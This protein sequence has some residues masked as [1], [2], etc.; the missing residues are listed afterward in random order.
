MV[1]VVDRRGDDRWCGAAV[2]ER[3]T[4]SERYERALKRELPAMVLPLIC[5]GKTLPA[6]VLPL[7]RTDSD[8]Q[9]TVG[10]IGCNLLVKT[11]VIYLYGSL[12][13][14]IGIV[15]GDGGGA[16]WGGVPITDRFADRLIDSLIDRFVVVGVGA[17]QV[18]MMATKSPKSQGKL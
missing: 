14:A 9:I 11:S 17:N 7:I 6:M 16:P 13:Q 4:E 1:R 15:D 10:S 18:P 2:R 8:L 12:Q 5:I 3:C